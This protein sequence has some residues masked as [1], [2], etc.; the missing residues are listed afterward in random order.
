[1]TDKFITASIYGLN[2][3]TD[4]TLWAWGGAGLIYTKEYLAG[5]CETDIFIAKRSV[6]KWR[7]I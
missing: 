2:I 3:K 5:M 7:K 1:M 4:G 6:V